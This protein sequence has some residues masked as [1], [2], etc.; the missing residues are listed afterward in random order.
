MN[1]NTSI[2]KIESRSSRRE[3]NRGVALVFT[4]LILALMMVLSLGMV[5]ALSSQTFISGYYQVHHRGAFYAADSGSNITRV[6]MINKIDSLVPAS[7]TLGQVPLSIAL[8]TLNTNAQTVQTYINN[9][10]G[11]S[12]SE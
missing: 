10:Y 11:Q 6:A 4:L 3:S 7:I 12:W 5:I 8:G 2:A 1:N 9:T